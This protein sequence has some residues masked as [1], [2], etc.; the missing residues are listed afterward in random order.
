MCA[1]QMNTQNALEITSGRQTSLQPVN[2]GSGIAERF[3]FQFPTTGNACGNIRR[4]I[5]KDKITV[6]NTVIW[7]RNDPNNQIYTREDH[8]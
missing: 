2:G 1:P 6:T 5:D 7:Q 4:N 3:M 8:E